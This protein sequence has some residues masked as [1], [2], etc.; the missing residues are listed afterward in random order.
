MKEVSPG[1]GV[2]GAHPAGESAG[3]DWEEGMGHRGMVTLESE[4][5]VGF[6]SD[7]VGKRPEGCSVGQ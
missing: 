5:Q 7:A 1:L 3:A 4:R 6:F 2:G